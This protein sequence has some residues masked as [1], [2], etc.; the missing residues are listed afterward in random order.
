[1]L[2]AAEPPWKKPG[3]CLTPTGT[4]CRTLVYETSGWTNRSWGFHAIERYR[5]RETEAI[6]SDG[7][8]MIRVS[9]QGF[10]YY[11][12]PS[13]NY[14]RTRIIPPARQQ[15][16]EIEHTLRRSRKLPGLWRF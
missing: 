16:F 12:V 13:G 5:Q 11:V 4:L 15:T 8:A 2:N 14:D 10:K 9:C 6:G 1:M 7:N 3:A